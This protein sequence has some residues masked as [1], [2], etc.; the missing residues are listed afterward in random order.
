MDIELKNISVSFDGKPVLRDLSFKL[1]ESVFYVVRG[2]SGCGKST[3][4]RLLVRLS[5]PDSGQILFSRSLS[6]T[7]LRRKVHLLPQLPMMF[8]GTVMD[9]LLK[10]FSFGSYKGEAPDEQHCLQLLS[11]FF[12]EGIE[13]N[14]KAADLSQGQKQRVA[15]CRTLLLNPEV[16]LCDEPAAALDS[17]SRIIVDKAIERYF[18][19]ESGK[20]VVYIS[21]HDELHINCECRNLKMKDGKLKEEL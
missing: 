17:D 15:L 3:L 18:K 7:E 1:N 6:V 13:P 16:L 11:D 10:P 21:H 12:P 2:H 9:N 20:T 14:K 8:E 19:S 5:E 4:L